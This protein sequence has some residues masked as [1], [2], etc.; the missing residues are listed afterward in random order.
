MSIDGENGQEIVHKKLDSLV[1][2]R[3]VGYGGHQVIIGESWSMEET[4]KRLQYLTKMTG[5]ISFEK[6]YNWVSTVD[7][8]LWITQE[9]MSGARRKTRVL[10]SQGIENWDAWFDASI[11]INTRT[12]SICRGGVSRISKFPVVNIGNGGGLAPFMIVPDAI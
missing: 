1:L 12:N 5:V 8:S 10:T 2:K 11:F 3:S 7:D 9:R 6:F 4:Q